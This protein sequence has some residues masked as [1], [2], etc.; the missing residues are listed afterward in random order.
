MSLATWRVASLLADEGGPFDVLEK[1]R[2]RL[3][4]RYVDDTSERQGTGE[5][6]RN[7][8]CTW[9]STLY[10]VAPFWTVFYALSR[11]WAI[12]IALPFALS[13]LAVYVERQ[14]W[15]GAKSK[16]GG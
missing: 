10:F 9:C 14:I 13:A 1:L 16:R 4:V 11:K 8:L 15:R 3:G 2:T 12:W 5:L 6:S 7:L